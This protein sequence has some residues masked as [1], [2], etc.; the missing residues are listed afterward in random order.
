MPW[1]AWPQSSAVTRVSA[2]RARRP[3]GTPSAWSTPVANWPE[4]RPRRIWR[5]ARRRARC[6]PVHGAPPRRWMCKTGAEK[7][8]CI[9]VCKM[10][11]QMVDRPRRASGGQLVYTEL[12]R[13][14]LDLELKPGQRLY[15]PELAAE[16]Q[17][18]RTPLREA[19]RLLLAE[20]LLDQLPTGGMVVRP[21]SARARSRSSTRCGPSLEGLMT[22]E[23]AARLDDAGARRGCGAGRPQRAAGRAARRRDERR[24]RLPPAPS[25]RSPGTAGPP[26]CTPRSTARWPATARSPTSPRSGARP[27]SPSTRTSS[28]R[29]WPVTPSRA[30]APRRGST[31]WP[32]ATP[33]SPPS[34]NGSTLD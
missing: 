24:P 22:A 11:D 20:D 28:R 14:I 10:G 32:P 30:R 18:S 34:P 23:A 5:A 19:L 2:S 26:G 8:T 15:E 17:V 25:P 13:Q 7:H 6:R 21:L 33:P 27:P 4:Q 3:A 16:L 12:R 29:W 31:S 9:Q 1:E